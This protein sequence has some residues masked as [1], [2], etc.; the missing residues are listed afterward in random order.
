[1]PTEHN[2]IP[3][4]LIGGQRNALAMLGL[5]PDTPVYEV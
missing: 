3:P 4:E 5:D 1:M 2:P